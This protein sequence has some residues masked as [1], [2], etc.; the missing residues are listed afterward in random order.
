MLPQGLEWL[1]F[2][3]GLMF[4]AALVPQAVRTVRLGRAQDMSAPFIL[5]VLG[6]S[7]AT[8]IYWLIEDVSWVIYYGFVANIL[9]WGLVLFYRL[10]P[11]AGTV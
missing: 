1:I 8:L 5:L 3:G 11:R 6:G 4:T 2:V 7:V 10:W 9:V